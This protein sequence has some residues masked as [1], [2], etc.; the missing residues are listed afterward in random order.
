MVVQALSVMSVHVPTPGVAF[1]RGRRA[2]T[3]LFF[4]VH[5]VTL[6][7]RAQCQ[8][9]HFPIY[10]SAWAVCLSVCTLS[11]ARSSRRFH[12]HFPN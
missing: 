10:P 7:T 6:H 9:G 5:H 8:A 4:A 11:H 2:L 3:F 1:G 12:A